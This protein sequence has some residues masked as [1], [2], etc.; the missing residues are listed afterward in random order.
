MESVDSEEE[1]VQPMLHTKSGQLYSFITIY[2]SLKTNN[3][4]IFLQ[5]ISYFTKNEVVFSRPET[6]KITKKITETIKK[7]L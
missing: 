7:R 4:R 6:I 5:Y 2:L 3:F 1:V